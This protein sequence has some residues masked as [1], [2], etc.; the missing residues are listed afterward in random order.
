MVTKRVLAVLGMSQEFNQ[1][2]ISGGNPFTQEE[3]AAMKRINDK[4]LASVKGDHDAGGLRSD[5]DS[6]R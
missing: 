5:A 6:S 4:L 2:R 3:I 1:M